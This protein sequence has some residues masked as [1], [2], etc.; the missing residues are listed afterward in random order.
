MNDIY[1]KCILFGD[2]EYLISDKLLNVGCEKY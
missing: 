1:F 2:E